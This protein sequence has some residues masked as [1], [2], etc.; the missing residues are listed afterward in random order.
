MTEGQEQQA[1]KGDDDPERATRVTITVR[2]SCPN[3]TVLA[4][5]QVCLCVHGT[6]TCNPSPCQTTGTNG[7]TVI[8]GVASARY[9]VCVDGVKWRLCPTDYIS[10]PAISLSACPA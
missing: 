10:G 4:G 8:V 7:Q 1:Q 9:D 5:K 2:E 3:G 6:T